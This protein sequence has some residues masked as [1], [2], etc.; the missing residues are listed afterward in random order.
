MTYDIDYGCEMEF[1]N[2]A[3]DRIDYELGASAAEKPEKASE[4]DI[5]KEFKSE[6]EALRHQL[7]TMSIKY[8]SNFDIENAMLGIYSA[9]YNIQTKMASAKIK[10]KYNS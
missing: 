8:E 6:F 9:M 7:V 4:K 3:S 10:Y 1:H 5:K 2:N